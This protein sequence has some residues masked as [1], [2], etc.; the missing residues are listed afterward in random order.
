M[1]TA[2]GNASLSGSARAYFVPIPIGTVPTDCGIQGLRPEFREGFPTTWDPNPAQT[3]EGHKIGPQIRGFHHTKL[4]HMG[5][6]AELWQPVTDGPT[7][8]CVKETS[9]AGIRDC[10]SC[11]GVGKLP[12]FN[13]FLHKVVYFDVSEFE[14]FS[15]TENVQIDRTTKPNKI[16]LNRDALTGVFYT[17]LKLLE[18]GPIPQEW[19][20]DVQA[21]KPQGGVVNIEFSTDGTNFYP[22]DRINGTQRPIGSTYIQLRVTLTRFNVRHRSPEFYIVRIRRLMYENC[23]FST[24]K[25]RECVGKKL[26]PGEI[27]VLWDWQQTT[28]VNNESLGFVRDEGKKIWTAPLDYFDISLDIDNPECAIF[29][30]QNGPHPFIKFSTG[31]EQNHIFALTQSAYSEQFQVFTYQSFTARKPQKDSEVYN[32]VRDGFNFEHIRLL[33]EASGTANIDSSSEGS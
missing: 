5:Y 11:H 33:A 6:P 12:G 15:S 4:Q 1:G 22:I 13:K 29:D 19:Q 18:N 28:P 25:S 17:N 32:K 8:T 24:I 3:F 10:P 14:N 7:C 20:V 21:K 31:I 27:L 23:N 9:Q 16:T 26:R 2:A 30:L